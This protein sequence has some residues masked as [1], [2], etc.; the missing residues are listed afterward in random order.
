MIN[1]EHKILPIFD[2]LPLPVRIATCQTPPPDVRIVHTNRLK[3]NTIYIFRDIQLKFAANVQFN[4][5][6]T[7]LLLNKLGF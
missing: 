3:Q 7:Y 4:S 6:T 2:P 5:S 1:D